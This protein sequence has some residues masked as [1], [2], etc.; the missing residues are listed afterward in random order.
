MN[1][2][3][4]ERWLRNIYATQDEEISYRH[5]RQPRAGLVD[6]QGQYDAGI[7]QRVW[8]VSHRVEGPESGQHAAWRV[9]AD[10]SKR[11]Q[12]APDESDRRSPGGRRW[13]R[14]VRRRSA[15]IRISRRVERY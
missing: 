3:R 15:D 1:R 10:A 2:D 13:Q 12:R 4:F 5:A 14:G 8:I 7:R 9:P 11:H 6:R